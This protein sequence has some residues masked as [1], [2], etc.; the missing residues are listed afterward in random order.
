MKRQPAAAIFLTTTILVF[1]CAKDKNEQLID[2]LKKR[3]A[4]DK[5]ES[6]L[7][8]GANPDYVA[9]VSDPPAFGL[10]PPNISRQPQ[11][12]AFNILMELWGWEKK[13]RLEMSPLTAACA[14]NNKTAVQLLLQHDA[15]PNFQTSTGVTALMVATLQSDIEIVKLLLDHG[16]DP[17]LGTPQV[18]SIML[19]ATAEE[20]DKFDLFKHRPVDEDL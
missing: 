19:A 3:A 1:S 5:I 15:N 12:L 18:T 20:F 6:L 7:K 14:T 8:A 11:F 17:M 16:A 10:T 13:D 2:A 9:M 4:A